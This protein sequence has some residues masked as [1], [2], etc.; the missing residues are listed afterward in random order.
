MV[1]NKRAVP[2]KRAGWTKPIKII[3]VHAENV[4]KKCAG[5]L[6]TSI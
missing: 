5:W 1:S 3:N 4:P 2:N 6:F